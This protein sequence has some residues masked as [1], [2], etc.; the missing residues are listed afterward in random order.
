MCSVPL[1]MVS[2]DFLPQPAVLIYVSE[3]DSPASQMNRFF[4]EI[5]LICDR[6]SSEETLLFEYIV[7]NLCFFLFDYRKD[8]GDLVINPKLKYRKNKKS[9]VNVS[10]PVIQ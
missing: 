6:L 5:V 8:A 3:C 9:M 2:K 7:I 1:F 10:V 4:F